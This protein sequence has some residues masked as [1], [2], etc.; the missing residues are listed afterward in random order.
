MSNQLHQKKINTQQF[1]KR[2]NS[3]NFI[4][5]WKPSGD[6]DSDKQITYINNINDHHKELL[7]NQKEDFLRIVGFAESQISSELEKN[8]DSESIS[9]SSECT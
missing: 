9:M 4:F 7:K 3:I 2:N 8:S 6:D 1:F 5:N